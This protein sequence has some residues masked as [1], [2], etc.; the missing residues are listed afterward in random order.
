MSLRSEL[1]ALSEAHWQND[2]VKIKQITT[3]ADL[4]YAGY[5][6]QLTEEQREMV[7]PFWFSIGR[8]YLFR[9]DNFPC[10]ISNERDEPVGFINL[11]KWLGEGDAYTWSYFIDKDHQGKGYGT[12]AAALAVRILKSANP[13]KQI[14]L[15]TEASNAKAHA[16]YRSLGFELLDERDG[17]DLVFGLNEVPA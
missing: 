10:V 11:C 3:E 9:E 14:K 8:A 5:D 15:A 17:D 13:R 4:I 7:N 6:C 12:Q 16:L 2:R 1:E